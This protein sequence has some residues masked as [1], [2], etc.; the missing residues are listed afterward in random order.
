M[1]RYKNDSS[2]VPYV[3]GVFGIT[4]VIAAAVGVVYSMSGK[5]AGLQSEATTAAIRA[6][7]AETKPAVSESA[8]PRLP[9]AST[10]SHV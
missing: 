9:G 1:S 10:S 3:G 7:K 6:P 4:V 2:L 8:K 5:D